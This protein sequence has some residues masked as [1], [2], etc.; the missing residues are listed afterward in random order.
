MCVCM[1]VQCV[2][3][4][5]GCPQTT[6]ENVKYVVTVSYEPLTGILGT[7]FRSSRI[8]EVLLL[9]EPFPWAY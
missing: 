9:A 3:R 6:K 4:V 1:C 7:E 5:C 8:S 2:F